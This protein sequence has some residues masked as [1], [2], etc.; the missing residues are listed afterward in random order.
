MSKYNAVF[1]G[2]GGAVG[3][4]IDATI[5]L[6]VKNRTQCVCV[7]VRANEHATGQREVDWPNVAVR[8]ALSVPQR[9]GRETV[10]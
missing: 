4:R 7:C 9:L 5:N 2:G 10:H 3:G 8:L 1:L 6:L